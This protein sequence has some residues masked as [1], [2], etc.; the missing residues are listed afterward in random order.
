MKLSQLPEQGIP[1]PEFR[2]GTV[3]LVGAG[4]GDPGLLTLLAL[5]ALRTADTVVYD[6]LVSDAILD[7]AAPSAKRIFAGKRGGKPSARQ[8]DITKHLIDLARS[9]RRV[10]RLKGGDPF[11]FGRG[12][13]EAMGLQRARVPFRIVP[14]ITAGIA[15]LSYAGIPATLRDINQSITFLTGHDH[16][17]HMPSAL[18]W[19][20][21][22]RGSQVLVM[23]MAIRH[24]GRIAEML[25]AGGRNPHEPVA[26]ISNATL[27]TMAVL[28]TNLS[29]AAA[30][31][32]R[33]GIE[34]PAI[35]CVGR[36]N[37]YRAIFD[38]IGRA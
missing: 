26:V 38:W 34:P 6:N 33:S 18:N 24:L 27:P 9:D 37:D 19:T 1:L 16:T 12:G 23:Y 17:G 13:D 4:P 32:E 14:G 3:W 36:V 22:A 8:D 35:V 11:I 10:L 25:I 30:D 21:L 5:K 15:A 7:L 28:E 20:A 31:V 2:P 29:E